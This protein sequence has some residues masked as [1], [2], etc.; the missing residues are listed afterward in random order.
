MM[1]MLLKR[2]GGGVVV[3]FFS[4]LFRKPALFLVWGGDR[5]IISLSLLYSGRGRA[6][7]IR[8]FFI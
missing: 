6:A 1:M 4:S 2:R 3:R 8:P 5:V 7:F